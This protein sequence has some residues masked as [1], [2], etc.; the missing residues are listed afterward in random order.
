MQFKTLTGKGQRRTFCCDRNASFLD[1]SACHAG[2]HILLTNLL[3]TL[4]EITFQKVKKKCIG[5]QQ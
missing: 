1:K 4:W 3:Q 5:K 2:V